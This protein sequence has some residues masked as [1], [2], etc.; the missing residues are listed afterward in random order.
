MLIEYV[1]NGHRKEVKEAI[2][3]ALI[4]VKAAREVTDYA[5]R[6]MEDKPK[7][8]KAEPADASEI[9]TTAEELD[10]AGV[11]WDANIHVASKLQN[12]DGTWRKKPGASASQESAE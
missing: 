6:S 3:R 1:L 12:K 11:S 8:Q 2:G 10:S 4:K 7:I 5:N 9:F